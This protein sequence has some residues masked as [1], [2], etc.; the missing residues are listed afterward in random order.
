MYQAIALPDSRF[1]S[2]EGAEG[3]A[4]QAQKNFAQAGLDVELRVGEFG[5]E[6]GVLLEEDNIAFDYVFLDGNHRYEPTM[7]YFESLLPFMKEDSMLILDDINWSREMER[8][9]HE[10]AAHSEVTLSLDLFF[11]GIAFIRRPQAKQHF[12]LRFLP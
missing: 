9:W 11:L 4:G 8:A 3:L 10:I 6:L 2:M 1:I 12:L 5:K 7:A